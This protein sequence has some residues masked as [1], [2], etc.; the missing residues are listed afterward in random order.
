MI[1]TRQLHDICTVIGTILSK[2]QVQVRNIKDAENI[3]K[4]HLMLQA[5]EQLNDYFRTPD[6]RDAVLL[7]F[8]KMRRK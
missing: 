2:Q 3:L 7:V 6:G 4:D 8:Q 1:N 5:E